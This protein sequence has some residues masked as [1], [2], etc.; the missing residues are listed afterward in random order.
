V[1]DP[2]FTFPYRRGGQQHQGM[3]Y[4]VCGVYLIDAHFMVDP[5]KFISGALLCLSTMISLVSSPLAG[6]HGV[7]VTGCA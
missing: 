5:S 7:V 1:T 2:T 6:G 3:G 4:A